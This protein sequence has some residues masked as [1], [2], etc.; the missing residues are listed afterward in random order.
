MNR[1]APW[2]DI[3]AAAGRTSIRIFGEIG[4]DVTSADFIRDLDAVGTNG[5]IEIHINSVG[6]SVYEG[7]P[8]FNRLKQHDGEIV[9]VVEGLAASMAS[10]IAMAGTTIRA[11]PA[12]QIMIHEPKAFTSGDHKDHARRSDQLAQMRDILI[13]IYTARTGQDRAVIDEW[14]AAETWFKADVA[15]ENGFVDELIEDEPADIAACLRGFDLSAYKR[16]PA[17]LVAMATS[18][19]G[20]A[21]PESPAPAGEAAA[22]APVGTEAASAA[23][24]TQG[25]DSMK[26]ESKNPAADIEAAAKDAVAAERKRVADVTALFSGH[27][28]HGDLLASAIADGW[29]EARASKELL[30][31]LGQKSGA[32]TGGGVVVV[33]DARDKMR[34]GV[35]AALSARAGVAKDDPRN[36]FRGLSLMEIA[37]AQLESMGVNTRGMRGLEVANVAFTHSGSDFP[38]L[39]E[40][41]ANKVLLNAY[42]NFADNWRQIAYVGSV[43][44]FKVNSRLRTG[45]FN[46][47]A[48]V[49]EGGEYEG[50]T[51]GE[52]KETIQAQTKGRILTVTRQMI[53]NDDLDAL[54]RAAGM[55]GRAAARTVQQDVISVLTGNPTMS[56]G[57]ALFSSNHENLA[58]SGAVISVASLGAARTAM[59]LQKEPGGRDYI[60]LTPS[61]L[62]TPVALEDSART[63]ISSQSDPAKSNSRTANPVQN[64]ATALSDPRLD[65]DSATAWYLLASPND[66]P[67]VEIAFLDGVETPF[68]EQM[69]GFEVDGVAWKVRLDYGVGANDFRGGYK[70]PGA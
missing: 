45:S 54:S 1:E 27:D 70:N 23:A 64:M 3:K 69:T 26:A 49:P 12:S 14:V 58:S 63:I 30:S 66:A 11:F 39:F 35:V 15:L 21:A 22:P 48:V 2:Y 51:F 50:G 36:E 17:E 67:V 37:R 62:L 56:D 42:G 31:A 32:P 13:D 6:G 53:V 9:V 38:A 19:E 34:A 8:I 65:A 59:R 20:R 18:I 61:I 5:D 29:D 55:L 47:L 24:T 33:E 41:T 28:G 16:A 52:E 46:D 7:L 68:T 10:V 60:G 57:N 25:V 4:W 40:D 44:D 43:S